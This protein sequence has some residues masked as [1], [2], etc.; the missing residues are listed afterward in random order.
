MESVVK[1]MMPV[2]SVVQLC[3]RDYDVL[4]FPW[5]RDWRTKGQ[6]HLQIGLSVERGSCLIMISKSVS[7][8]HATL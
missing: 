5:R 1:S 6:N 7:E 4:F 3:H 2:L 8:E